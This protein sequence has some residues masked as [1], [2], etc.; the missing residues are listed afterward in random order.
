M[1]MSKALK[2]LSNF[3]TFII[4]G[5]FEGEVC[6]GVKNGSGIYIYTNGDKLEGIWINGQL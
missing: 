5:C 2:P 3:I 1:K 6:G 4:D